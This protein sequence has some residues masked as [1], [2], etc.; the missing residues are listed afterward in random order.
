MERKKAHLAYF[1]AK[2]SEYDS[3]RGF[4]ETGYGGMRE[5]ELLT[6]FS[7]GKRVLVAACGT[8]RLLS[9]LSKR[10][11]DVIGIDMSK[12]M[13]SIAR[14]KT[15]AHDAVSLIRCDAEFLPFRDGVFDEVICSRAFK[16]FPNPSETLK[17]WSRI[18]RME[19][20]ILIS[21]ETSSPLWIKVGYRLR[22]PAMG[23]RF[24][25][26]YKVEDVK[27]L[28]QET[29]FRMLFTGCVIY[30]GRSVYEIAEKYFRPLLGF[31]KLID[32]H[33]KNG[34]NVMFVAVKT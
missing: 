28:F 33:S 1:D 25:W 6:L 23:S 27:T 8:G 31:L 21:L 12:S 7:R 10:G 3:T 5:R 15:D 29:N 19:G 34:R 22:L 26:R 30:F 2:A 17:D 16:L 20:K 9:F 11:F 24:E 4:Y 32:S 14:V 13:L 18:L